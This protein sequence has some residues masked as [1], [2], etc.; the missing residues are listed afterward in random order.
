M[1]FPF[2]LSTTSQV[3]FQASLT[4]ST[5]PSLP[6]AATSQRAILR[7]ALKTHKR[8]SPSHQGNNYWSLASTIQNYSRFLISLDLALSGKAVGGEDVDIALA[9]EPEIEWRPTL[10]SAAIPG[11]ENERVR[12]KGLDYEIFFVHHTLA[13]IQNLLARQSLL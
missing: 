9:R 11:R 4:S 12:G 1:P 13:L 6:S 10:S 2:V 3:S 5:H 7:A 8:L